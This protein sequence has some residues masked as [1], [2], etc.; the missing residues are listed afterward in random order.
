M[1]ES[2]SKVAFVVS[3]IFHFL[4]KK[5]MN[6][7]IAKYQLLNLG[8]GSEDLFHFSVCLKDFI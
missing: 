6:Q 1:G 8:C 5:E 7:N 2:R 4:R 3:K